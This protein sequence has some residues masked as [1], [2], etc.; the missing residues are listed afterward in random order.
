MRTYLKIATIFLA[1]G[2]SAGW[3][4]GQ[5]PNATVLLTVTA[6]LQA[7]T[8]TLTPAT[9]S[10]P[11]GTSAVYT[12]TAAAPSGSTVV[13]TGTV[14][15][16]AKAPTTGAAYALVNTFTLVNGSAT[17]TYTLPDTAPTGGYYLTAV[18]SGDSNYAAGIAP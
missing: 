15:L 14:A 11:A 4:L 5:T 2:L 7:A 13:P 17:C 10:V 18:Y 12:F 1:F 9:Q 3:A 8:T 6:P 16:Y